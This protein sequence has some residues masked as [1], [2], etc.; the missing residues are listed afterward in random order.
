M[1]TETKRD[2]YAALIIFAIVMAAYIETMALSIP[3]WDSGEFIATSY[4]LGIPHPPGTPLYVLLG[5][6][7]TL[8]PFANVATRVNFFSALSSALAVLFTFLVTVRLAKMSFKVQGWKAWLAGI[9]A[10]FFMAFSNTFWLNSTEAEV[11]SL[12]SFVML[13]TLWMSFKWWDSVGKDHSDKMLLAIAYLLSLSV[14]IHL[15]TLLVAPAI[16]V[17]V[18]LVDWRTVT[19]SRLL[20]A[21][22]VLFV[23]GVSVHL[24]LLL[25]SRL[26]PAINEDDPTTWHDLW[27]VLKRDQY[28]PG[29]VF[30]R[31]ADFGFQSTMFWGYFSD[32]F[33]M[34][35]GRLETLGR[36]LP[37]LLGVVG[38]YF[39]AVAN[40]KTFVVLLTVFLI[41]S[42]GLIIYLN[43][44]D[45]EVRER[46]YFY[47]A[48]YH[49]FTIWMGLGAT[50]LLVRL[51]KVTKERFKSQVLPVSAFSCLFI[52]ASVLP[53]FHFHFS[54]DRSTD[55][56]A[57]NFAY[58]M[59]VPLE[60]D[61]IVFTNGDNDTF[62][63][64]CIQEIEGVR[65]DVRVANL[66][67][68]R[69]TWYVK[70]LRD[71]EPKIPMT[72]DDYQIDG[73]SPYR[74]STGKVW[75]TNEIV[76][77]NVIAA[78]KWR[79][80]VYLAVTVPDQMGLEKQLLLEGL[81]FRITPEAYGLRLN[82]AKM[83]HDLYQVFNWGG[84][85][86]P[87][88]R[89][90]ESFYK[91]VNES[92]LVQNYGAAFFTLAFWYRQTGRMDMAVKELER[93]HEVSPMFVDA[94]RWLG[95]FYAES[96]QMEKGERHYLELVKQYPA[97]AEIRY[98]LGAVHVAMGKLDAAIQ[99]YKGAIELDPTFRSAYAGLHDVY[100]RLGRFAESKAVLSAWLQIDPGDE[101]VRRYL[102]GR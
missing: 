62:P 86:K 44:T 28:K 92:R 51:L 74:D 100:A 80:P 38:A 45:H 26:Y 24:Y 11:Y 82:E 21:V 17:M 47:V 96:G 65:K 53:Y 95:Q 69:T 1:Y 88:G 81:V 19:K 76:V 18:L 41:C 77:H 6:I 90:D 14:G 39:H 49:F 63:L 98:R 70:Q 33:T 12:S 94:A 73:L 78:N 8:L 91:D 84:I 9:V 5:R 75:Q 10:S 67:L 27:L 59:L 72:L 4:I 46:D 99:D 61:A 57:R 83:K 48:S 93:S 40:K 37:I 79:K 16:L 7:F 20:T 23:L 50:G 87:D 66:S 32:Q 55:T 71:H 102:E 89:R 42:L 43:F 25:R 2:W 36:Y 85:L 101:E 13:L 97:D 58:N 60:K 35:G 30:V 54:H 52:L 31:R 29:S 34:W 56:I 64:W 3:F 15:G 68:L 22:C